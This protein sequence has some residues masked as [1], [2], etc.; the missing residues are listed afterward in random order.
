MKNFISKVIKQLNILYII[1]NSYQ[2]YLYY[3]SIK[4]PFT[5]LKKINRKLYLLER[6][7]L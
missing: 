1:L 4:K 7:K 5:I 2:F 6:K 3:N